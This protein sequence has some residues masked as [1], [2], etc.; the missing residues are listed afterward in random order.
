MSIR[1]FLGWLDG[2]PLVTVLALAAAPLLSLLWGLFHKPGMGA[3]SPWKQGYSVL[4]Y[5][6]CVPGMLA[7]VLVGYSLF[8]TRENLLDAS[9]LSHFLPLVSMAATL[10]IIRRKV[11][12][13]DLPGFGRLSGLMLLIAL[14]FVIALAIDRTRIFFGAFIRV[15]H[16]FLLAAGVFILLKTGAR[17]A[18]GRR[19]AGS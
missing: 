15:E 6:A 3:L 17:M 14:S 16:L 13:R 4:V 8:F 1:D 9:V 18:V 10:L 11:D 2:H 5:L 19:K 12:F 7:A